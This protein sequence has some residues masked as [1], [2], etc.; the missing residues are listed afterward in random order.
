GEE[1]K[2]QRVAALI[3]ESKQDLIGSGIASDKLA[4]RA[5]VPVQLVETII[6]DYARQNPGL[7]AKRLDGR[8]VLFREGSGNVPISDVDSGGPMGLIDKVRTLFGGKGETA[9]KVAF[10]S[11]RKA[12]LSQQRDRSYED[13]AALE[14]QEA[15][16][17]QQFKDSNGAITKRRI[18]GQM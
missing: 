6:R 3:Q 1:Q 4:D 12:A 15:D 11:E 7:Q 18:T 10:L 13:M 14:R 2:R 5:H 8:V 9:K 17:K 16:L